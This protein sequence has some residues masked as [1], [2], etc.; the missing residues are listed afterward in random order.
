MEH[1]GG[2]QVRNA[3]DGVSLAQENIAEVRYVQMEPGVRG[4]GASDQEQ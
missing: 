2:N 4:G 3:A 1:V